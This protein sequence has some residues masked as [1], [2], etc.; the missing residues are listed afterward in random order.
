L[1]NLV[2]L[3][4]QEV[5]GS[6]VLIFMCFFAELSS[7][8]SLLLEHARIFGIKELSE[9]CLEPLK[10]FSLSWKWRRFWFL[11]SGA[12]N[13]CGEFPPLLSDI[14]LCSASKLLSI[15]LS[16]YGINNHSVYR[17]QNFHFERMTLDEVA[18]VEDHIVF[19]DPDSCILLRKMLG[20]QIAPLL[21]NPSTADSGKNKVQ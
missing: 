3:E 20:Q 7:L 21:V 6:L 10:K 8:R 15:T 4:F 11:P 14:C 12:W 2:R 5:P 16:E 18:K 9:C 17:C 13:A 19:P 1:S